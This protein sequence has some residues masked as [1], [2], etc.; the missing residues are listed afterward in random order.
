MILAMNGKQRF[1]TPQRFVVEQEKI[2]ANYPSLLDRKD[3]MIYVGRI[4]EKAFLA[5]EYLDEMSDKLT[6]D[7]ELS[8]HVIEARAQAVETHRIASSL[9]WIGVFIPVTSF[10][11]KGERLR[12]QY[13]ILSGLIQHVFMLLGKA[14]L[15]ARISRAM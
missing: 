8:F 6:D 10:S 2:R 12:E 9:R 13:D 5:V 14:D 15:V 3:W 1:S 11:A 7:S 4:K